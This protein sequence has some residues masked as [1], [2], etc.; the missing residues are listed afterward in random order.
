MKE[1]RINWSAGLCNASILL[2]VIWLMLPAVQTTGRAVSGVAAVAL[3]AAGVALDREMWKK[4]WAGLLARAASIAVMP[5]L[6]FVF[7]ARGGGS[8]LSFFVQNGMFFFPLVFCGYARQRGDSRLWRWLK[9]VLLTVTV[10]TVVTTIFWLVEGMFFRG[11]KVYAYSRSLGSAEPGYEAYLKELM[12]KN[13][14]GYDFVYAM[15]AALPLTIVGIQRSRGGKRVAFTALLGLQTIMIVL[16]QYTYAMLY[17]AVILAVEILAAILRWLSRGRIEQG[18]S[19]LCG[20]SPLLLVWLLRMPLLRL[21]S[22]LFA[23]A[24]LES[25]A[26]SLEQLM[27]ALQGGTTDENSRLVHYQA[28]LEGIRQ[29]PLLGSLLGGEKLLSRHSDVLDVLSGMGLLGG[30]A[31]CLMIWLMG[32]GSLRG[33][34]QHSDKAQLCIVWLSVLVTASL[35]TVCYSREIMA[36][37]ALGTLLVLEGKAQPAGDTPDAPRVSA[38]PAGTLQNQRQPEDDA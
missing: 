3:F 10:V 36:V 35:G 5:V 29:S 31:V 9:P 32:R 23:Q 38:S 24:G 22:G 17:A 8:F 11:D 4:D 12:L 33:I 20:L 2:Y 27:V 1:R 19:L 34:R 7:M 25:F 13:I 26:F 18:V 6:L 15:V 30:A 16:S 21:A 14:G 28:A 37:A